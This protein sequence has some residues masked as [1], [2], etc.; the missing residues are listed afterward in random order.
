MDMIRFRD[1]SGWLKIPIVLAWVAGTF[2]FIYL[3][4]LIK[5][6]VDIIIQ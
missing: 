3:L 2:F 1:L 6:I 4:F 5:L